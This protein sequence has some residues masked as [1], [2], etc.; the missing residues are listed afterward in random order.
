MGSEVAREKATEQ[1]GG[2]GIFGLD[3]SHVLASLI[4]VI[5]QSVCHPDK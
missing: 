4:D 2:G 3:W 1:S 5:S